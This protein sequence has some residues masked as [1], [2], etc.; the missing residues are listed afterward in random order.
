MVNIGIKK[1][2]IYRGV[3]P[4]ALGLMPDQRPV[5]Q[6]TGRLLV[7]QQDAWEELCRL[8][9]DVAVNH[10]HGWPSTSVDTFTSQSGTLV[11]GRFRGAITTEPSGTPLSSL[12]FPKT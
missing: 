10:Q 5:I 2:L 12:T 6:S 3:S 9:S 8:P 11:P 4:S 1:S 7:R